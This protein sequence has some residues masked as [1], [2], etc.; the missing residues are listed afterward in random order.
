MN[1]NLNLGFPYLITVH[2]LSISPPNRIISPVCNTLWNRPHSRNC[3]R[4][5]HFPLLCSCTSGTLASPQNVDRLGKRNRS[6]TGASQRKGGHR[7]A[8]CV[9]RILKKTRDQRGS[10]RECGRENALLS[11]DAR[12]L[13]TLEGV[14]WILSPSCSFQKLLKLCVL[15]KELEVHLS[16]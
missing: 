7:T 9:C 8:A 2:H 15:R 14:G 16:Q 1:L 11:I 13:R 3:K 5:D 4:G 6:P 10:D 12:T